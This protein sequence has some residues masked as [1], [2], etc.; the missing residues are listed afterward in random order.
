VGDKLI[1]NGT[2]KEEPIRIRLAV[3][4]DNEILSLAMSTAINIIVN[5]AGCDSY[6]VEHVM[7]GCDT[8]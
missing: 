7:A 1:T 2:F 3:A 6:G 5:S 8:R 4:L